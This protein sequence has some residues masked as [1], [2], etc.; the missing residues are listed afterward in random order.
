MPTAEEVANFLAY[1]FLRNGNYS[2][3]IGPVEIPRLA[4]LG[5]AAADIDLEEKTEHP[6]VFA[7]LA[8]QSV[9]HEEGVADPRVHIYLT[10]GSAKLIRTMPIE[11]DGVPVRTH[12]MG[13]ITVRPEAVASA[14]NRGHLFERNSRVCCGSSC[15]P[16]SENCSGTF[17]A[18][19]RKQNS[20]VL[21]YFQT[22]TYLP[23]AIMSL[24]DNR[25]SLLATLIVVR[26]CVRRLKSAGTKTFKNCVAVIRTL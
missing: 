24:G 11:L 22:I 15:A 1:E 12:K 20:Q 26:T 9:G 8:V 2:A 25:S 19:V 6:D 7:A 4:Q 23:V 13:A 10:R 14:T 17:G 16:T 3:A 18:I 21:Y 5:A